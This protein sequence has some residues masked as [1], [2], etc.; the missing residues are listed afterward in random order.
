VESL[1]L[2]HE[3]VIAL[4]TVFLELLARLSVG[5][6]I[7]IELENLYCSVAVGRI[8]E[9]WAWWWFA[10]FQ[11]VDDVENARWMFVLITRQE[12]IDVDKPRLRT[13]FFV[14]RMH[15]RV[16]FVHTATLRCVD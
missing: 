2:V 8:K 11:S 5:I 14:K 13:E 7:G 12:L 6:V 15:S 10:V 16:E 4:R 3:I 9:Y 1:D